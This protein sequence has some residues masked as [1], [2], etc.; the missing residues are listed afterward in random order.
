MHQKISE[1]SSSYIT[2]LQGKAKITNTLDKPAAEQKDT[3][4]TDTTK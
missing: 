1:M 2:E 4:A 3:K